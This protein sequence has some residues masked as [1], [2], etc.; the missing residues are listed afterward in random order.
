MGEASKRFFVTCPCCQSSLEIDRATG[1]VIHSEGKK[2]DYS[3]EEAVRREHERKSRADDLF[4]KAF[5]NEK[6]RH[7][8]LEEKFQ[9]ALEAKD[10]LDDPTRPFDL[11]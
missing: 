3:L 1:L 6:S 2:A 11:D 5:E 10:E 4:A 9:K 8:S 7:Q